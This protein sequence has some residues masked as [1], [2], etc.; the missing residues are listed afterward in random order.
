M[1]LQARKI[2]RLPSNPLLLNEV[3]IDTCVEEMTSVILKAPVPACIQGEIRL[4]S[5]LMG[6]WKIT[7]DPAL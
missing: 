7:K 5:D 2:E 1:K 6:Q 4:K 3:E